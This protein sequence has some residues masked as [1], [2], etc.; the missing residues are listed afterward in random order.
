VNE[1]AKVAGVAQIARWDVILNEAGA[2]EVKKVG[3]PLATSSKVY[4]GMTADGAALRQAVKEAMEH[5]GTVRTKLGLEVAKEFTKEGWMKFFWGHRFGFDQDADINVTGNSAVGAGMN[6]QVSTYLRVGT[7]R[8][9]V[10]VDY[11]RMDIGIYEKANERFNGTITKQQDEQAIVF[12]REMGAGDA[13]AFVGKFVD[14]AG[15]V[16]YH[17]VVWEVFKAQREQMEIVWSQHDAGWWCGNGPETLRK[18][19]DTFRLWN[20]QAVHEVSAVGADFEKKLEDGKVVQL[21]ALSRPG[22]WLGCWWDAQGNPVGLDSFKA[23][24]WADARFIMYGSTPEGLVAMVAVKGGQ[25]EWYLQTP[26]MST[27]PRN[28]PLPDGSMPPAVYTF[29]GRSETIDETG[30]LQV[31]VTVGEWEQLGSLYERQSLTVNDTEYRVGGAMKAGGG[32][33]KAFQVEYWWRGNLEN[34]DQ[35]VA[36]TVDGK[37]AEVQRV[38]TLVYG[39][40]PVAGERRGMLH[41]SGMAADEVKEFRI[42]QRRRE[43]VVFEGFAREPKVVPRAE[44]SGEEIL[45]AEAEAKGRA[46]RK[47]L[48]ALEAKRVEWRTVA[49][50]ATTEMGA[51]RM[52]VTAIQKGDEKGVRAML[53]SKN[54]GVEEKLGTLAKVFVE[55]ERIRVAAVKRYGEVAVEDELKDVQDFERKWMGAKWERTED[56]ELELLGVKRICKRADGIYALSF[57]KVW[58]DEEWFALIVGRVTAWAENAKRTMEEHPEMT[59]EELKGAM[60]KKAMG[61]HF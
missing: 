35:L 27:L 51:L 11:P 25:S 49:A 58:K 50:D 1:E 18:W 48:A 17:L 55:M 29:A 15:N 59:V 37:T 40:R 54:P 13:V 16:Y 6:E 38:S 47:R 31:G 36:A 22:K 12:S 56:G 10:S 4:E 60:G 21:L 33:H 41:F 30:P 26:K 61:I 34:E 2:A 44:V 53:M 7:D 24:R 45:R 8:V 46:D 23:Y 39:P 20:A 5:G 19:A 43:W 42:Y 14:S 9:K 57:D 32:E 52:L 28:G 3:T